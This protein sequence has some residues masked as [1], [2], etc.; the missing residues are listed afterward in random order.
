MNKN[1][2]EIPKFK[3]ESGSPPLLRCA[4]CRSLAACAAYFSPSTLCKISRASE[5][6]SRGT[7]TS[8]QPRIFPLS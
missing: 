1:K 2:V 3:N 4:V 8:H 5:A 7:R 6:L